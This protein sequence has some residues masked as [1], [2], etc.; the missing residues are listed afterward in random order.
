MTTPQI[1]PAE[2]V[3]LALVGAGVIGRHH[4]R[5]ISELADSIELAA[6]VDVDLGRAEALAAEHGG[7]SFSSLTEAL[8]GVDLDGV[9]VC[10][11]PVGTGW[12][13][14]KPCGPGSM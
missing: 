14:S 4:A 9:V 10:T 11:R 1:K 5:V 7:K 8:A 2:R 13:P 6:V 12:W 3:R